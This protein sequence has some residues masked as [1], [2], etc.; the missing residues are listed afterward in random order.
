MMRSNRF[1][2][3]I[4][5]VLLGGC[6][7]AEWAGRGG[8]AADPGGA[9]A[10]IVDSVVPVEEALDRF[11]VDLSAVQGFE[12]GYDS[13]EALVREV[14]DRLAAED[15]IAFE[16]LAVNRAEFAWL[17]YPE[18]PMSRPPYEL[19]PALTWFRLQQENRIGVLRMLRD[20]GGREFE[21]FALRCPRA[22]VMEGENR[23]LSGCTVRAGEGEERRLF[24]TL[25]ERDGRW[26]VL[27][28]AN[29]F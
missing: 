8:G 11:R 22:A 5:L 6:A 19:P 20:L 17:V 16:P 12:G 1:I 25:V 15:T 23:L 21:S 9:A 2:V 29:D 4:C 7:A 3:L 13:P 28:F 26:K 10:A 14:L 24:G 18:S 27:S